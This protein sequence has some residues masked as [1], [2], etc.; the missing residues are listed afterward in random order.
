MAEKRAR[1]RRWR[2]K[3]TAFLSP[4]DILREAREDAANGRY[5]D[6]ARKHLWFHRKAKRIESPYGER[7]TSALRDWVALA[8]VYPPAMAQ[9][10]EQRD[11]VDKYIRSAGGV[12]DFA[13]LTAINQLLDD[14]ERTLNAFLWLDRHRPVIAK[15]VLDM[16]LPLLIKAG[17]HRL[18][19]TYLQPA[20][21]LFEAY[22]HFS[23]VQQMEGSDPGT[24]RLKEITEKE[25][26][27]HAAT[28]VALV[29]MFD[30]PQEV[31]ANVE[32]VFRK[33]R[34]PELKAMIQR[35]REGQLPE[36]P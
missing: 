11:E 3:G 8:R 20:P 13:E 22:R 26:Y 9:I 10:H 30:T 19:F 17:K 28:I 4:Y 18:A 7:L 24:K 21:S 33:C 6:A 5:E 32:R 35:A 16:A 23:Y 25:F 15:R 31:A 36:L 1:I 29:A 2:P 27:W 14:D 34:T 12:D